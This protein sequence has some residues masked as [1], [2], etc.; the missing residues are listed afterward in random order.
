MAPKAWGP[1]LI[2]PATCEVC[3]VLVGNT[4]L[5]PLV[6]RCDMYLTTT[7]RQTHTKDNVSIERQNYSWDNPSPFPRTC[8]GL[9]CK[10][11][12]APKRQRTCMG[13]AMA[14]PETMK[15]LE[16]LGRTAAAGQTG[17]SLFLPPP[18]RSWR[19]SIGAPRNFDNHIFL[20]VCSLMLLQLPCQQSSPGHGEC[21]KPQWSNHHFQKCSHTAFGNNEHR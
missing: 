17:P 1:F 16:D 21:D 10:R 3:L 18:S 20:R 5:L 7:I 11:R 14:G 13:I 4:I 12:S 19:K 6:R 9:S 2:A 8:P 15:G